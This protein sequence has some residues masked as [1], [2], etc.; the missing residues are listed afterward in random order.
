MDLALKNLGWTYY[1]NT[2]LKDIKDIEGL[3]PAR[4]TAVYKG[5]YKVHTGTDEFLAD[6]KGSQH[7]EGNY[8]A[9]GDWV[10]LDPDHPLI[11]TILDRKSKISR[12]VPGKVTYEQII[13]SNMDYIFIVTSLNED[14]NIAR[15]ERYLTMVYES[16][17]SPVFVLTKTDLCDD[18]DDKILEVEN[19]SFGVPIHS[20]SNIEKTGLGEL[21]AYFENHNTVVMVG[22][23]GVGK[24][25]LINTL[26]GEDILKTQDI[27]DHDDKG[28]HTT[29]HRELFFVNN[30]MIIDTPGMRE[31]QLWDADVETTFQEIETLAKECRFKDCSHQDEPGCTVKAAL[32]DGRLTEARYNSY[33]KLKKEVEYLENR[34]EMGHKRAEKEKIKK[35]MGSLKTLKEMK[36]NLK[37]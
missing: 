2:F 8:P 26:V 18:V 7:F 16:G 30:G 27:R 37:R 35:M 5:K 10:C 15:L 21:S 17:A 34:K 6:L 4:V 20:I 11:H 19:I 29:T 23:S 14:F 28:R 31:L 12:K 9:V 1:R 3:R 22:S 32:N 25:T 33:L 13:A 36:K 24:S